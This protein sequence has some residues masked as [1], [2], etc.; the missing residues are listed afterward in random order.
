[1]TRDLGMRQRIAEGEGNDFR[2]ETSCELREQGPAEAAVAC[3]LANGLSAYVSKN[4][5]VPGCGSDFSV[6]VPLAL[7]GRC[8]KRP[9]EFTSLRTFAVLCLHCEAK[10]GMRERRR[11][12]RIFRAP[13]A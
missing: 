2:V 12:S 11:H 6:L 10:L 7:S 8:V 1:M 5:I 9:P 13:F 4:D 3:P